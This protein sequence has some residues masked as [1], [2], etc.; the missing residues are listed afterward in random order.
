MVSNNRGLLIF[1]EGHACEALHGIQTSKSRTNHERQYKSN[2]L[3]NE[4][5]DKRWKDILGVVH[6]DPYGTL[7]RIAA[8]II[9]HQVNEKKKSDHA[10]KIA[11][12]NKDD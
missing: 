6:D 1:P 3:K 4:M 7:W 5:E 10:N 12:K 8:K 2:S 11:A 9:L